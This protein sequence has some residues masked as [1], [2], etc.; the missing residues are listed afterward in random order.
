MHPTEETQ[1]GIS[2]IPIGKNWGQQPSRMVIGSATPPK[3]ASLHTEAAV[4]IVCPN[5]DIGLGVC[6]AP[7]RQDAGAMSILYETSPV[8]R[9]AAAVISESIGISPHL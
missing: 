6:L 9:I 5:G 2:F 1:T 3:I 7:W 4:S 8:F